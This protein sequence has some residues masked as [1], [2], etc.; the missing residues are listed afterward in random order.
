MFAATAAGKPIIIL[1]GGT[2]AN[3]DL[4]QIV[5]EAVAKAIQKYSNEFEELFREAQEEAWAE[6][7]LAG[8]KY[9]SADRT[10]WQTNPYRKKLRP[11][12]LL[13]GGRLNLAPSSVDNPTPFSSLIKQNREVNPDAPGQ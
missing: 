6:G 10:T 1:S 13:P 3:V 8:T 11:E 2:L 12:D 9:L 4:S 5:N 7:Y